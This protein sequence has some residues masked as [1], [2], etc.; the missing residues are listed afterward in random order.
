MSNLTHPIFLAN[1]FG[2]RTQW[3]WLCGLLSLLLARAALATDPL[4]QNDA[5]L[6][7]TVPGN[8]P[9]NIDA[10]N[11]VNNNTFTVNFS[12][13]VYYEPWNVRNYTNI[14]YMSANT[15]F[16][17]DTQTTN[18]IPRR[19]ANSFYNSANYNGGGAIPNTG[20]IDCGIQL[21]VWAT[22]I[23]NSGTI[24][25]GPYTLMQI[26]GGSVDFSRS[27]TTMGEGLGSI[28]SGNLGVYC[29]SAAVGTD[30]NGDWVPATNLVPTRAKSSQ[31]VISQLFLPNSTPYFHV[32]GIGTSNVITWAIFLED[33]SPLNV[34]H[35]VYFNTNT[36]LVGGGFD[37]IEWIGTYVDPMTGT[38]VNN[39]LYLNDITALSTNDFIPT[40][41]LFTAG[42]PSN[43]YFTNYPTQVSIGAPASAGF[44]SGFSYNPGVVTNFYS[45]VNAQ[46]ISTTTATNATWQN[47]S[48][49]FTNLPD[50]IHI[51]ANQELDLTLAQITGPNYLSLMATNQFDGS[52]GAVIVAP[53]SDISL[54]AT[55]GFLT[56]TNLLQ[57]ALPNWSGTIQAWSG[58]WLFVDTNSVTNDFR[59]LLVNSR[60]SPTTQSQVQHFTLHG[61]NSVVICDAFNILSTLSID[62]QNLTLTT[63][64]YGNGATSHEGELNLI[65]STILWQSALPN[66]RNLTNNGAITTENLIAFGSPPPANY[67]N[68]INHGVISDQ[69]S[70][71]YANYFEN[72]GPFSCG[73][74]A[75]SFTLQ[76]LITLLTNGSITAGGD[77]SITTGSLVASNLVLQAGRS[78]TLQVTNLLTDTGVANGNSWSV[79]GGSSVGFNLPILPTNANL[80]GTTI[81]NYAPQPNKQVVNTWAGLDRGAI[82][83]GYTNNAAIGRLILDSLGA[84]SSFK[85]AGTG[86]SNALYVDYLELRDQATNRDGSG[87]F[88]AI[89]NAPNMVIY[90]AQAMMNGVSIAEKMNFKN[91][92]RLRWVTNY[93]GHFSSTNIVFPDS[94]IFPYNAALA[95]SSDIDSDGDGIAN[96]YDP[97]PFGNTGH[98]ASFSPPANF[99]IML[100][101]KPVLASL[102]KWQTVTKATNYVFYKTNFTMT[103]WLSLTNFITPSSPTSPPVTVMMSDP[104]AGPMRTYRVRVDVKQ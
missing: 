6:N 88:T 98:A 82:V 52:A 36:A 87:N 90:Y 8:P 44:P 11:F 72:G 32:S 64:G 34:T 78:L 99:T 12:S 24:R 41:A 29:L 86:T 19:M 1:R 62:A 38:T 65:S 16:T 15:G 30:T 37:T 13:L 45:Y 67:T 10:T 31:P 55:N 80:L 66:L 100:T 46:L 94:T 28:F 9:P 14:G 104:V 83:G 7:Y 102:L 59:V 53:Y 54:G 71:I 61:T 18:M 97:T 22:N 84:N 79:G 2:R 40:N 25:M 17:F 93:A 95:Q 81:T 47:P 26:T 57:A 91:G 39:Y 56:V 50:Q 89:S 96:L 33:H 42:V 74:G 63:N 5:V 21:I 75:G 3:P 43:F 69:G 92:G 85:F 60:V 77:V 48:G 4:Y 101:N 103:N 73:T 76:S 51:T 58:R 27:L 23:V 20:E 70:T 68:F 49:A 35:N